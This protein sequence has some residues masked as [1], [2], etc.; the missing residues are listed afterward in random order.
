M[1]ELLKTITSNTLYLAIAVILGVVIII[2][3]IKKMLK[4]LILSVIVIAVYI[5]YLHYTG[6]KVP[7]TREETVKHLKEKLDK[8]KELLKDNMKNLDVK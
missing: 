8:G 3:I 5:G 1:E 2:C 7:G 6:Q 4:L